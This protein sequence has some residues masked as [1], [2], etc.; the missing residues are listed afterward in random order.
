MEEDE[1]TEPL[2]ASSKRKAA[3]FGVSWSLSSVHVPALA[4]HAFDPVVYRG[5]SFIRN[6]PPVGLYSRV[7]PRALWWLQGG[8]AF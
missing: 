6:T 5:T 2:K 3:S 4:W 7:M 8:G 1:E